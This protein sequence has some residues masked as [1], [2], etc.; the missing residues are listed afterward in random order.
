MEVFSGEALS[1]LHHHQARASEG[2]LPPHQLG[3]NTLDCVVLT[4]LYSSITLSPH[5]R[6]CVA[7]RPCLQPWLLRGRSRAALAA[8]ERSPHPGQWPIHRWELELEIEVH[9][10]VQSRRRPLL[11]PLPGPFLGWKQLWLTTHTYPQHFLK[12]LTW[13]LT[14]VYYKVNY[15]PAGVRIWFWPNCGIRVFGDMANFSS[16]IG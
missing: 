4:T 3:R 2:H 9:E 10:V 15:L 14:V 5:C 1:Y 11:G 7:R 16:E 13:P 6:G 8:V 12:F